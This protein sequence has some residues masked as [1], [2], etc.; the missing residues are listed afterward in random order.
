MITGRGRTPAC[1]R[2]QAEGDGRSAVNK[3][4][5]HENRSSRHRS[6]ATPEGASVSSDRGHN[7]DSTPACIAARK[8]CAESTRPEPGPRDR[9]RATPTNI[10][11][12]ELGFNL[13]ASCSRSSPL[14]PCSRCLCTWTPADT[15]ITDGSGSPCR[16]GPGAPPSACPGACP[17]RPSQDRLHLADRGGARAAEPV[18]DARREEQASKPPDLLPAAHPL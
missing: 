8:S 12:A 15:G 13:R 10:D 14:R 2:S 4:L 18:I 16:F 11:A 9:P 7:V 3:V 5:Q 6:E 17:P 1:T